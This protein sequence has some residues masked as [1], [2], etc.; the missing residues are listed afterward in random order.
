MNIFV[1]PENHHADKYL[2]D[3][4]KGCV[5]TCCKNARCRAD[6]NIVLVYNFIPILFFHPLNTT[7]YYFYSSFIKIISGS[8]TL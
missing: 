6:K 1:N 2:F 8:I 7:T 4:E 3:G 5:F